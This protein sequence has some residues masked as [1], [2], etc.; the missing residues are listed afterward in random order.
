MSKT[1]IIK[2]DGS[3]IVREWPGK[4]GPSLEW[5]QKAVE[6][7]IECLTRTD[8]KLVWVNEE[9]L[10]RRLPAQVYQGRPVAGNVL[11]MEGEPFVTDEYEP[12]DGDLDLGENLPTT[13]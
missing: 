2:P 6:G 8:D 1:T 12:V 13:G 5:M 9:G 7:Y 3:T 4:S 11:V 10:L